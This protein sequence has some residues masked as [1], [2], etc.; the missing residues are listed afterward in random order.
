[1]HVAVVYI[2]FYMYCF[3]KWMCYTFVFWHFSHIQSNLC[4]A[5]SQGMLK[6]WLL[7]RDYFYHIVK[8]VPALGATGNRLRTIDSLVSFLGSTGDF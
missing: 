8:K 2:K 5:S 3:L 1:M 6:M 4:Y 7:K